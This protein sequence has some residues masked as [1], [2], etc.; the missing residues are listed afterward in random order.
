MNNMLYDS[1]SKQ[2]TALLDFDFSAV[3]HPAEEFTMSLHDVGGGMT[4]DPAGILPCVLSN[5]F[6]SLPES[7]SEEG[8]K[9]WELAKLW[10]TIAIE[11]GVTVLS[12]IP[13]IRDIMT[14]QKL[15]GA[16]C[17]FHLSH[18]TALKN[19]SDES[20]EKKMKEAQEVLVRFL[21]ETGY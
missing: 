19:S 14:L 13:G 1:T 12:A 21:E 4:D 15:Y 18:K 16:L 20:K 6:S 2:I 9:K 17:P 5:D 10:N 11:K 8:T 7:L 3:T